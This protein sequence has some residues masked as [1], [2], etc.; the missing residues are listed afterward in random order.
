MPGLPRFANPGRQVQVAPNPAQH[1]R[2]DQILH[3]GAASRLA[4]HLFV[5]MPQLSGILEVVSAPAG[6]PAGHVVRHLKNAE[7]VSVKVVDPVRDDGGPV[8]GAAIAAAVTG[9]NV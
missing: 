5:R 3:L 9:G 1:H 6:M 2:V 7:A 8:C 4:Q